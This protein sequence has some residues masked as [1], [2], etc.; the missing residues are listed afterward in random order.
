MRYNNSKSSGRVCTFFYT[1]KNR[2]FFLA[3]Q[4]SLSLRTKIT[5][6]SYLNFIKKF[7]SDFKDCKGREHIHK[8]KISN[9]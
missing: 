4:F 9:M 1:K 7:A 5:V 6:P 2:Y 3:F 8:H